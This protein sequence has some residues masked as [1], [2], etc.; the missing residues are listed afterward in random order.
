MMG[1]YFSEEFNKIDK[2]QATKPQGAF[3]FY[4]DF[5][6]LS[7]DLKRKGVMTSNE[8]GHSLLSHP[9][10]IATVTGDALMLRPDNYGAR[11]A[12]VDYDGKK[13][14]EKYKANPPKSTSDV[15]EYVKENT[16]RMINGIEKLKAYVDDLK[17]RP[18]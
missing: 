2:I 6:L 11:I 13:A 14:F 3:Y 8:L 4:A 1:L 9:H 15:I 10:H 17:Q 12:F 16:P 7:D 18:L 5:N